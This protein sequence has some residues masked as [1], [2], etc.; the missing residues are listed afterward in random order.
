[1][2][3]KIPDTDWQ[4]VTE[5]MNKKGYALISEFL[6]VEYCKELIEKYDNSDLYR[7]IIV[8]GKAQVR[9]GYI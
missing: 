1:M 6:P 5:E 4:T 8:M 3:E 9:I 7:K 2:H